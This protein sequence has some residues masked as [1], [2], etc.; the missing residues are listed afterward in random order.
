MV[1]SKN[2]LLKILK[3]NLNQVHNN[4]T[5]KE[6]LLEPKNLVVVSNDAPIKVLNNY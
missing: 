1:I 2:K 4:G 3:E 5:I 6:L